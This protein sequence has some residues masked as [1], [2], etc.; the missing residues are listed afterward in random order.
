M[1]EHDKCLL[2]TD[3]FARFIQLLLGVCAMGVLFVKREMETPKRKFNVWVFDVSKQGLGAL[4]VHIVNIF[5]SIIMTQRSKAEDDE[6]AIYF[7][8]FLIDVTFGTVLVL[9]F[10]KQVKALAAYMRWTSIVDS[11]EYG[12]PPQFIVWG[13]QLGAYLII[14]IAMKIVVTILISI[15][16]APLARGSTYI[17]SIFHNHRHAELVVVMILGPCVVNVVQFWILDNYLK[18]S[19]ADRVRLGSGDADESVMDKTPLL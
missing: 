3:G 8:T 6:C 2:L 19:T 4:F 14:L 15:L 16:F 13:K 12:N 10:L 7:V 1:D 9:F 17:F 5:L 11:G 18:H